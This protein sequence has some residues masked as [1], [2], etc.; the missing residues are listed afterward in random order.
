MGSISPKNDTKERKLAVCVVLWIV[1]ACGI[2]AVVWRI[3][4]RTAHGYGVHRH[5]RNWLWGTPAE[6][7]EELY[8]RISATI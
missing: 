6:L 4:D 1:I 5:I 3:V 7:A 8:Y 2:A